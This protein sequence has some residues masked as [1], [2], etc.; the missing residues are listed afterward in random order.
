MPRAWNETEKT[1]VRNSLLE[2]GR[3]LFEKHGLRKTTVDEVAR[4]AGVSKGAFYLF[5]ESKEDLYLRVVEHVE[6]AFREKVYRSL[7]A[8]PAP[9]RA[10]FKAFLREVVEFAKTTPIVAGL[11][12]SDL[13]YL[14]RKLPPK[15]LEQH[16]RSDTDYLVQQI[17]AWRKNGWI[18]AVDIRGLRGV[19]SSLTYLVVHRREFEVEEFEASKD[20]LI[21]MIATYVV[22][23]ERTEEEQ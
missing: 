12:P 22:P 4:A 13:Q 23:E 2:Q 6:K 21:E 11:D 18:R 20:L 3:M 7:A 10:S 15:A 5:F 16:L 8:S 17:Q 1:L 9:R 14:M 19:L